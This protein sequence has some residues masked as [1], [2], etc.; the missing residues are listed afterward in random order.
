MHLPAAKH[1]CQLVLC[2]HPSLQQDGVEGAASVLDHRKYSRTGSAPL[3]KEG[4]SNKEHRI[5]IMNNVY[6]TY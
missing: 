2:L 4:S 6:I 3:P 5:I 1:R